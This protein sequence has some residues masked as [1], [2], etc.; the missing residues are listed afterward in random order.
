MHVIEWGPYLE[1]GNKARGSAGRG[2][3]S[4]APIILRSASSFT[5]LT[6]DAVSFPSFPYLSCLCIL[7]RLLPLIIQNAY[8]LATLPIRVSDS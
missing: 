8:L 1:R 5:T 7:L 4:G 6:T 3:D 2:A